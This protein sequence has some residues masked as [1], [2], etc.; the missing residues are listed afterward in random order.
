[1]KKVNYENIK[2]TQRIRFSS[3]N[4]PI[5]LDRGD[6][7][8]MA[9]LLSDIDII[10]NNTIEGEYIDVFTLLRYLQFLDYGQVSTPMIQIECE[11]NAMVTLL[12]GNK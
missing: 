2:A 6:R 1:M 4:V 9:L 11:W 7:N 12:K 3:Q 8:T 10:N 5:N